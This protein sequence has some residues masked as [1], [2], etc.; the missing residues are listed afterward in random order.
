MSPH[1][2]GHG[3][4]TDRPCRLPKLQLVHQGLEV[5]LHRSFLQ[6]VIPVAIVVS[7]GGVNIQGDA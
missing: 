4:G 6:M 3:H 1:M 7:I 5:V 2:V